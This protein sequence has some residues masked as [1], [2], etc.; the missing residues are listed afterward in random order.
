LAKNIPK[1]KHNILLCHIDVRF[2]KPIDRTTNAKTKPT[3]VDIL[4]VL[5]L[6]I[7]NTMKVSMYKRYISFMNHR[8]DP[9]PGKVRVNNEPTILIDWPS[10]INKQYKRSINHIKI[11]GKSNL[12]MCVT[13]YLADNGSCLF[14]DKNRPYPESKKKTDV[15]R[16]PIFFNMI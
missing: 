9:P 5:V 15:D 2:Q 7:P 14:K 8:E 3:I 6:I 10:A 4:K 13:T 12:K 16:Y 1:G 11:N